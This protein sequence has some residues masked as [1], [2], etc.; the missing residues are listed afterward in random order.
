M[1]LS[2]F[3]RISV[4]T[5]SMILIATLF[6]TVSAQRGTLTA[7]NAKLSPA[8]YRVTD[9]GTLSGGSTSF[10]YDINNAGWIAASS[11]FSGGTA[12]HAALWYK[13][14]MTDLG[15]LGGANSVPGGPNA[16]L[17]AFVDSETA[18]ADPNNEDMCAYGTHA[19]CVAAIWRDGVLQ[20]LP[21]LPG[22]NNSYAIGIN[23]AGQ[24]IGYAE[25]D[26]PDECATPFQVRRFAP[27]IWQPDGSIRQLSPLPGDTVGF[28]FAINRSGQAVGGSGQ[29]SDT[30][31]PQFGAP[32]APHGVL[33]DLDGSVSDLGNL[34][35]EFNA[36][37][38]INDSGDVA[39]ASQLADGSL[40]AYIWNRS[41]GMR[42]LGT[43]PG[44]FLSAVT[45]CR[46]LNDNGQ[47][48]GISIGDNGPRAV[49]WEN[50]AATDLNG[51]S[52]G[53]PL[54]LV[55]ASGINARGQITGWGVTE[56]GAVHGFLATPTNMT[57]RSL[58]PVR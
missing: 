24:V 6:M 35:G 11:N 9:I 22:G 33:W 25:N 31:L 50:G 4:G 34:G 52:P 57:S 46:T 49:L 8:R 48:V 47:A 40:H 28:G 1:K 41:K 15:T 51:I 53:S 43:L 16:G 20:P 55:F 26:I 58:L 14:R 29:C 21:L 17:E 30:V 23:D 39:G 44:D 13:G 10:G 27:V 54:Y 32:A 38:A 3:A 2:Q 56:S 18:L 45:C 5:I 37:S 36:P 42:D 19:Q 7:A 12:Q